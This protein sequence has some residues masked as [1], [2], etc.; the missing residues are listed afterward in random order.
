MNGGRDDLPCSAANV[1][2]EALS[3]K[4]NVDN[5]GRTILLKDQR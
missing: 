2:M 3:N 4:K 1:G 5:S